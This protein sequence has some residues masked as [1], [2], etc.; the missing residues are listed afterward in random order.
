MLLVPTYLNGSDGVFNV[1]YYE[2]LTA[3][4]FTVYPSYYEPWG[5][6]PMESAAF[7]IPTVTTDLAGFG[8]WVNEQQEKD[9]AAGNGVRV[10]HRDDDNYFEVA[11]NIKDIILNYNSLSVQQRQQ[12]R[13]SAANI[14]KNAEWDNFVENYFKAFAF[15][16]TKT[17]E[18]NS[19]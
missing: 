14:V 16:I 6:T 12:L 19:K 15:A 5:Y 17:K 10:I 18:R 13:R 8:C 9:S 4:D 7:H 11:E 1:G 3:C 2:L